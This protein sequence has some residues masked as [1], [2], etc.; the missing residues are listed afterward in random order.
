MKKIFILSFLTLLLASFCSISNNNDKISEAT[1]SVRGLITFHSSDSTLNKIFIWAKKQALDYAFMND[2]V[3]L[4]YEAALPGREAFCMRDVSHQAMGAHFLGLDSYT[5]NMLYTMANNVTDARDWCSLWEINRYGA[6][7]LQDYLN[8]DEFWYNL[9]ANFDILDCCFRMYRFSGDQD[10]VQD[11][12]FLN[13][14]KKTVYDYV[15]RWNLGID[16][17][18]KREHIMNI[19]PRNTRKFRWVR[20][21]PGYDEGDGNYIASLDLLATEQAAFESYARLQQLGGDEEEAFKFY[22]KAEEVKN[23]INA[24]CWDNQTKR[25]Y[26]KINKEHQLNSRNFDYSVLYWGNIVTDTI[27]LRSTIKALVDNLPTKTTGT[28]IEVLSHLPEILYKY[29]QTEKAY[30]MLRFIMEND[31]REYPE[32]SFST[33]GAIVTGLM[34]IE[35]ELYPQKESLVNGQYGEQA[36]ITKSRL[37][38]ETKWAEI[39]HVPVKG[40]II[41]VRHEGIKKTI[42]TNNLGPQI[43]WEAYFPGTH[44]NLLVNGKPVKANVKELLSNGEKV[45]WIR[46]SVGAGERMTVQTLDQ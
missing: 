15:D 27:K 17:V 11:S 30:E 40:N 23:F 45:S 9:P 28:S 8:D 39:D 7:A 21:I 31:R 19:R 25:Y 26:S 6:P 38:G 16:K 43:Q 46:V 3:G 36:F 29:E 1:E 35:M 22:G 5:K 37:N 14:Y 34:G 13:F 42:F 32:A 12:V 44:K 20:G 18:M 33:I 41:S 2:P 24:I 4:W 10:Y